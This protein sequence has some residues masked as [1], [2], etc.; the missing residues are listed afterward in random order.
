MSRA[1]QARSLR[2]FLLAGIIWPLA[3]FIAIGAVHLYGSALDTANAAYDR[4]LVTTAYSVGD[5]ISLEGGQL[6]TGVS[7]AMVEVYEAG[8]S[9][10]MIYRISDRQ[11]R[12]IAGD[13]DLPAYLGSGAAWP[14]VPALLK[15]YQGRYGSAP[16]RIAAVAQPSKRHLPEDDVVI[17]IAEPLAFREGAVRDILWGTVLR[18]TL[19]VLTVAAVTWLVVGRALRPIESLR[20]QLA[21]RQE[22]DLSPLSAPQAPRELQPMVAALNEHME[23]LHRTVDLQQRFVANASHQ[24]RTPLAVLKMQLQSGARGDIA[25]ELALREMGATVERATN[26]ANQLLSLARIEQM[27]GQG[28]RERCDLA[29]IAREVAIDLSPLISDKDLDFELDAQ[30]AEV[31][32]RGWMATEMVSNLLHNAIRHT[33]PGSRLGIRV[34]ALE[35]GVELCVWDSGPGIANQREMRV[36]EA[37]AGCHSSQGGGLGLTICAEIADSMGAGLILS[38]R[39]APGQV[40]GLDARVR[41]PA[42][43]AAG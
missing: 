20:A 33:P 8:F 11:G 14:A 21:A 23:R 42:G 27:R 17:Q 26:V 22:D 1:P 15:V 6:R 16:V 31:E 19:L 13:R 29:A 34:A 41:F 38:N 37:F 39:G 10:R 12:Y 36:F 40:E 24:L 32:G 35:D 25:P 28:T 3:L 9:T 5:Q 2:G 18:Q 4:M 30:C 7:Y 43:A